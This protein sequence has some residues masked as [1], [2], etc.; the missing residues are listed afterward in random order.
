MATMNYLSS[1]IAML[2]TTGTLLNLTW[3]LRRW[4]RSSSQH[5]LLRFSLLSQPGCPPICPLH[6]KL[7]KSVHPGRISELD[8]Q[9]CE[10]QEELKKLIGQI[11]LS[12]SWKRLR[13]QLGHKGPKN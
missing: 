2:M 12:E 6:L 1:S 10:L 8:Y 4:R 13:P 11:N 5:L 3:W 9:V 7:K